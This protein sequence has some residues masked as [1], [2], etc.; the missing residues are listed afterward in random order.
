MTIA[1]ILPWL[2]GTLALLAVALAWRRGRTEAWPLWR[3][4]A[5]IALQP[6]LALALAWALWP[7]ARPAAPLALVVLTADA[8][9]PDAPAPG[10]V[11]VRLPEAPETGAA[12]PYPDLA[13][14]LRAH[15]A[16]SALQVRGQGLPPRDLDAARGRPLS[17][18]PGAPPTGIVALDWEQQ[19]LAGGEVQVQGRIAGTDDGRVELRD[20]AGRRVD[21]A[22]PDAQGRFRLHA[23]A[24]PAGPLQLELRRLDGDGEI[25]ESVLLPVQVQPGTAHRLRLVAG[26]PNPEVRAL[27]RW[28]V[29]AGL[30][31]HTRMAVGGGVFIGDPYRPITAADLADTDLMLLDERSWRLLGESGRGEVLQ[32]VQQG[33]GLLLRIAGPLSA[34]ER[35]ALASLGLVLEPADLA[36]AVTPAPEWMPETRAEERLPV[37]TRQ[38]LRLSAPGGGLLLADA[39]GEPLAAW[40]RHGQGRI[41]AWLLSGS[42]RWAQAGHAAAHGRLWADAV[43]T[44]ARPRET[45]ALALPPF[46][47]VDARATLCGLG[48][49][50]TLVSPSG[51]NTPLLVDPATGAAACAA[52]WP[53]EPGL[54]RVRSG[55]LEQAWPVFAANALPGLA[56]QARREATLQLA[57]MSPESAPTAESVPT[58]PGPRWPGWLAFLALAALAWPL[59]RRVNG[60]REH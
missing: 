4:L 1:T 38:P 30:D 13:S 31:L 23:P 12:A 46:G 21:R 43:A 56:A 28:A 15:P 17:F 29:D 54:H 27:R 60:V 2:L 58:Q 7:P 37:L 25:R 53:R 6:L 9:V 44:L 24:G 22:T 34:G 33:M 50:A 55:G 47:R 41:G 40:Q 39:A 18:S 51:R 16:A 52:A 57:A 48:N 8:G 3:R 59:E 42:F 19:P 14:A 26:A 10:Q 36:R 11:L 49:A 35:Q 45:K 5:V 32:A 20:P